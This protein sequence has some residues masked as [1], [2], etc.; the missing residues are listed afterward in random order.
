MKKL[1]LSSLLACLVACGGGGSTEPPPT[2][3]PPTK[4]TP[5]PP[6]PEKGTELE[7]ECV[8]FDLVLT[9]A[10][11]EGGS[12]EE[13][14]E[15]SE[16]CGYIPPELTVEID[17]TWGD[18]FRPIVVTVSYTE[19]GEPAEWTFETEARAEQTPDG[20]LVYGRGVDESV[21]LL[22]NDE[23]YLLNLKAEPRCAIDEDKIDCLGYRQQGNWPLIYYGEDDDFVVDVELIATRYHASSPDPVQVFEGDI[24][25]DWFARRV[26]DYNALLGRNGIFIRFVLKEVWLWDNGSLVQGENFVQKR[27]ADIGIGHGTTH[28]GTCGVAY[29]NSRFSQAGFGFSNCSYRT[30]LH[31][32]GHVVGLHHGPNNTAYAGRGFVFPEFGHG[33]YDQCAGRTDDIMAYGAKDHFFN[34]RMACNEVF[35]HYH[36]TSP[37]GDRH[38]ADSAYHWN[39]VRYDLSL[40]NDENAPPSPAPT[41]TSMHHGMD[42]RPLIID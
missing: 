41:A 2:V 26:E 38:R 22:V 6:P 31:E 12:Y 30:D 17:D 10:D 1:I 36:D 25:Y 13:V 24:D 35:P 14:T 15:D 32:L 9:L 20:L 28:P 19:Q 8:G 18:R 11:G 37:A 5:P 29:P 21:V 34:S 16:E 39:R 3:T 27:G 42:E 40:I 4:P 33:D 7:R 23:E